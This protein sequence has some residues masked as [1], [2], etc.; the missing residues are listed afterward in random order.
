MFNLNKYASTMDL[1]AFVSD[2][3]I[4]PCHSA[5]SCFIDKDHG[6]IRHI[7][8]ENVSERDQNVERVCS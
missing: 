6:H 1:D 4:L 8:R 7:S 3:L 2:N 5:D